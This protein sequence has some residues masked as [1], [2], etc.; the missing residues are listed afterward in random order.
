MSYNIGS[1]NKP[2]ASHAVN[3]LTQSA[4]TSNLQGTRR[5]VDQADANSWF[6]AMA[7]AWGNAL[8]FVQ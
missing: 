2:D 5:A 7:S 8:D 4:S 1:T 3:A 6:E